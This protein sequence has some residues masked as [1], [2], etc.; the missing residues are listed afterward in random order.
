MEYGA[1]MHGA[2]FWDQD[3]Y[4]IVDTITRET[5]LDGNACFDFIQAENGGTYLLECNPRINASMGFLKA[6]G[7]NMV[8][9]RCLQL[10]GV[11]EDKWASKSRT[12]IEMRK[13][14]ES[15]YRIITE[16]GAE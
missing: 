7:V 14:Y 3:A 1:T 5:G 2:T 6:H 15:E 12:P 10:M 11:H 9:H 8:Y 4:E 16:A 13:H